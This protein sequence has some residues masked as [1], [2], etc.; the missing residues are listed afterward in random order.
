MK[1]CFFLAF[2]VNV[3]FFFGG[4]Q[5]HVHNFEIVYLWQISSISNSIF[6]LLLWVICHSSLSVQFHA[7]VRVN[8]SLL[9]HCVIVCMNNHR[10]VM[11]RERH[12]EPN[13]LTLTHRVH[14]CD[15][16]YPLHPV[17]NTR[18]MNQSKWCYL[19]LMAVKIIFGNNNRTCLPTIMV[20]ELCHVQSS[21]SP[22]LA[23]VFQYIYIIYSML[24]FI[25]RT[26]AWRRLNQNT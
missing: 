1:M 26:K 12:T 17:L 10:I 9:Y 25:N 3:M 2:S 21:L 18:T 15:C 5:F 19:I 8:G 24:L 14:H 7:T 13:W 22:I 11:Q 4:N 16:C 20:Q 23:S 6:I